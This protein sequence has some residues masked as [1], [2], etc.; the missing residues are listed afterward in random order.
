MRESLNQWDFVLASYGV[1][2]A[3]IIVLLVWSVVAMRRAE[4]R[5]EESRRK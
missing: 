5:R 2:L 4:A 3:A 1:G